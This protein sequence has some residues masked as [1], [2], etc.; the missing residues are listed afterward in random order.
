[1]QALFFEIS[2][3]VFKEIVLSFNEISLESGVE[4]SKLIASKMRMLELLDLNGNKFGVDG[5][6]DVM[7]ILE[8]VKSAVG[9]MSED[10]GEDDEEEEDSDGDQDSGDED[11]D[12]LDE[13]GYENIDDYEDYDEEEDEDEED[14]D[15][16][17]EGCD[18]E[19]NG[20]IVFF[21]NKKNYDVKILYY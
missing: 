11:E 21:F 17:Y 6:I 7:K 9:P 18:N 14:E 20:K 10:E 13:E 2:I 19:V 16:E 15:Y 3:F 4:L 12:A 8:P 1:L 5:V